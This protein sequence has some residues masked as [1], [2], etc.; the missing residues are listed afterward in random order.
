MYV[1]SICKFI[2][3][4]VLENNIRGDKLCVHV[5]V[6]VNVC[7]CVKKGNFKT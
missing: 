2:I 7:K 3:L 6:Q 5:C 4:M 1:Y